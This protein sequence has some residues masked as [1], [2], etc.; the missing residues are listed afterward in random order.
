MPSNREK[1][2]DEVLKWKGAP[3]LSFG[4]QMDEGVDCL[5]LIIAAYEKCFG[6]FPGAL[7]EYERAENPNAHEGLD[8]QFLAKGFDP[9][10]V[11][12]KMPG[13][14][15]VFRMRAGRYWHLGVM[16]D[17]GMMMSATIRYGVGVEKLSEFWKER[18]CALYRVREF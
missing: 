17:A 14:V 9:M 16:V 11:E 7:P 12:K 4:R 18:L 8:H 15:L 3:F 2:L 1:F 10:R 13:D 6:S 5:G